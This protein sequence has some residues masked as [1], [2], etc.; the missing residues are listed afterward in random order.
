MNQEIR[1]SRREKEVA[2]LLLQGKSNKQI[3]LALSISESTVEF[4]LKN[5]YTKLGVDSRVEAT[6]KLRETPGILGESTV[7]NTDKMSI[8]GSNSSKLDPKDKGISDVRRRISFAE[9]IGYLV[10]HKFPFIAWL[11]LVMVIILAYVLPHRP[12]WEYEREGEHPDDHTVGMVLQ[13]SEASEQMAHGQF[14]TVPA[15]PAQAGYVKYN[16][17]KKIPE[18]DHLLLRLRYSKHSA[19]EVLILVYLDDEKEPRARILPVNQGD[20]N[21]F[22]WTDVIDLG[23]VK[24]G[25]HSIKFYTD[26]QVYGVADLDKFELMAGTP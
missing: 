23:E 20:W 5:I 4:H 8:I 15:W 13:R 18:T 24:R 6:I 9:I 14:G 25:V 11:L 22:I 3:A 16:I 19:S 26:G 17:T 12:P 21:K 1:L 2:T 7:D 10:T